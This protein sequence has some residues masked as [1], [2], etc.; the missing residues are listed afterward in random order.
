MKPQDEFAVIVAG[1]VTAS[2]FQLIGPTGAV[3]AELG[4]ATV[5]ALGGTGSAFVMH[6]LDGISTDSAL[7][8]TTTPPATAGVQAVA[9]LGPTRTA[10]GVGGAR[11]GGYVAISESAAAQ[12]LELSPGS[13]YGGLVGETAAGFLQLSG[14]TSSPD[15]A[16]A[17][18]S[19]KGNAATNR[20]LTI[21]SS[22]AALEHDTLAT[23]SATGS[24]ELVL[25]PN[26]ATLRANVTAAVRGDT[27]S[28]IRVG[29]TGPYV[30]VTAG[31]VFMGGTRLKMNNRDVYSN[32]GTSTFIL[33]ASASLGFISFLMVGP[34]FT[35]V[36]AGDQFT[37]TATIRVLCGNPLG[38]FIAQPQV[39]G[40]GGGIIAQ[41]I[42]ATQWPINH[43]APITG[44]WSFTA[45]GAGAVRFTIVGGQTGGLWTMVAPDTWMTVTYHA[46]Q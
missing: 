13:A 39:I 6:H 30:Q 41:R 35:G 27:E 20:S 8:W 28:I 33:P 34:T 45:T 21:N 19:A 25:V 11:T 2:S 36:N 23:V 17:Y 16:S 44:T 26:V 32:L 14:G 15:Q 9:L 38:A 29:T 22:N 42:V 12:A 7:T 31:D 5:P 4:D 40:G 18:L 37:I 46:L 10:A 43:D 24:S 3:V 1:V